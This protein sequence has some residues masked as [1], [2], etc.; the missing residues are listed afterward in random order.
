MT[1]QKQKATMTLF[2]FIILYD[3][4]IYNIIIY[5]NYNDNNTD[6][7]NTFLIHYSST[8]PIEHHRNTARHVQGTL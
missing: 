8:T 5:K 1:K 2:T 6:D 4:I 3:I 7:N